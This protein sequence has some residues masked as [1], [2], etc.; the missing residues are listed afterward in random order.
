MTTSKNPILKAQLDQALLVLDKLDKSIDAQTDKLR[1]KL[2]GDPSIPT[3]VK[4]MTFESEHLLETASH[5]M[6]AWANGKL[7]KVDALSQL[8]DLRKNTGQV[9][10]DATSH[11]NR[12]VA[13]IDGSNSDGI[14]D[15]LSLVGE[16]VLSGLR[17]LAR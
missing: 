5:I 2:Y 6:F 17:N 4:S 1:E 9:L 14:T 7:T 10:P 12:M 15:R 8:S 3:D 11:F 13:M 16:F